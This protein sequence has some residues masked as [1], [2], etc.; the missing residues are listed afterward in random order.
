MSNSEA[1]VSSHH[2]NFHP[3]TDQNARKVKV[4][5]ALTVVTMIVEIVVGSWSGSM[6]LLADGWHMGTHAAAFAITMFAYHYAKKHACNPAF[7]FGTG[8]VQYLGGFASA[9]ALSVVALVMAVE[10]LGRFINPQNIHFSEAIAVASVGLIVNVVS[11]FILHDHHHPHGED[12][13][14]D[15]HNHH[16]DHNLK[17]AYFHVL[18]DALTSVLAIVALFAGWFLGW[19][20]LDAI[21]GIVGAAIIA[22]WA[23]NLIREASPILLDKTSSSLGVLKAELEQRRNLEVKDLHVWTLAQNHLAAI[24]SVVPGQDVDSEMIRRDLQELLPRLSHITVELL[25]EG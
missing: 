3:N 20:W 17:A 25:T 7:S 18:A 24:V 2:H 9:V 11:V 19:I 12:H 10:S 15:E 8:K 16:H 6:A 13:S 22:K 5:F 23:F 1:I 14:H 21:M 4:V